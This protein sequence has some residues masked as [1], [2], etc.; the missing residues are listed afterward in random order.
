M[1]NLSKKTI[2][3]GQAWTVAFISLLVTFPSSSHA[4]SITVDLGVPPGTITSQTPPFSFQALNGTPLAGQAVSLDFSFSNNEFVR[5]FKSTGNFFEVALG[6]Q[7]NGSGLLGFLN[8]TGHLTDING[9]P[10]PGFGITGS[11][12]SNSGELFIGLFPL[13]K[14]KNGTP[15]TDLLRPF[16]FYDVHFAITFPDIN[17]PSIFVTGGDFRLIDSSGGGFGVG[18]FVPDSGSTFLLLGMG[19]LVV[20]G[21]GSCRA[22]HSRF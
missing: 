18:P 11:A 1:K 21:Y 20:I 5:I 3:V 15:N 7:T 2:V 13:L 14:D 22:S 8:G 12:S 17:N 4:T 19:T 16:D 6:F 9:N 10:I